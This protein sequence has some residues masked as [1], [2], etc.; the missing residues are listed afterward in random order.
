MDAG[1]GLG[2]EAEIDMRSRKV[3]AV[4]QISEALLSMAEVSILGRSAY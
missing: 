1:A 3:N 4:I 2:G